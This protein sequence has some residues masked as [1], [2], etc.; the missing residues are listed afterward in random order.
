MPW[1]WKFLKRK[2]RKQ[3]SEK[4]SRPLPALTRT[5]IWNDG[6]IVYKHFKKYIIKEDLYSLFRIIVL[7]LLNFWLT[8]AYCK[9]PS[10]K[11]SSI[12]FQILYLSFLPSFLPTFFPSFLPPF[13]LKRKRRKNYKV[14]LCIP[15]LPQILHPHVSAS[16]VTGVTG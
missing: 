2:G 8:S 10:Y 5:I 13:F 6:T 12:E 16:Q 1:H 14:S 3:S 7:K 4:K 9:S 11:N 15:G